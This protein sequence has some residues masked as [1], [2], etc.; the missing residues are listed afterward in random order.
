[1]ED[2]KPNSHRYKEEQKDSDEKKKVETV[3]SGKVKT[4]KNQLNLQ[5][6]TSSFI[7]LSFKRKDPGF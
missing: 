2:F 4:K 1:M 5:I 6:A 7:L 3:I